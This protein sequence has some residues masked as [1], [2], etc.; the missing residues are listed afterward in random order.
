MSEDLMIELFQSKTIKVIT[1]GSI[2][3]VFQLWLQEKVISFSCFWHTQLFTTVATG[4][5]V[6]ISKKEANQPLRGESG[7]RSTKN[8][9]PRDF[10]IV[11]V[12]QD[13]YL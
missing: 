5:I 10:S 7:T 13:G 9:L 3:Q 1:I 8:I 4:Q 12:I 2:C 6:F 11:H